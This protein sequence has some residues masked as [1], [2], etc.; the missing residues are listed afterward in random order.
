MEANSPSK[1]SSEG[2]LTGEIA[3]KIAQEANVKRLILSHISVDY[4]KNFNPKKEANK[5]FK[6]KIGI[7][8]DMMQIRL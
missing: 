4:H 1:K 7:A 5:F 6:G 2:H 8:E 3:G